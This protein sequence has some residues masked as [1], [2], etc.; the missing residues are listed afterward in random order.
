MGWTYDF[1]PP[2]A[3]KPNLISACPSEWAGVNRLPHAHAR[4]SKVSTID[5][6]RAETARNEPTPPD[7][8]TRK[9]GRRRAA[10]LAGV[11]LVHP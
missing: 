6:G 9:E 8:D 7:G 3:E 1:V 10:A 5:T 2:F 11:G 4:R